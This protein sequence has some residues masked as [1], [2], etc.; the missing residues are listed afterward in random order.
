ML[1]A[2]GSNYGYEV[3]RAAGLDLASPL[4]YQ[5]LIGE[6]ATTMDRAEALLS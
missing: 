5:D 2:G 4:P 1:R 3:L 6:F